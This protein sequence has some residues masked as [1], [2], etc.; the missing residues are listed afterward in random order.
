MEVFRLLSRAWA[1][2]DKCTRKGTDVE[3]AR[4]I[5]KSIFMPGQAFV[6]SNFFRRTP[7]LLRLLGKEKKAVTLTC[8]NE[9][10]LA[11]N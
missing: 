9:E 2:V 3:L 10:L 8:K 5:E 1:L 11:K 4:L 6:V 7:V